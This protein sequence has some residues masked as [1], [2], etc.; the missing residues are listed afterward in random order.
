ML[1]NDIKEI[2]G[3]YSGYQRILIFF[4]SKEFVQSKKKGEGRKYFKKNNPRRKRKYHVPHYRKPSL[5][6][7]HFPRLANAISETERAT[8]QKKSSFFFPPGERKET[9]PSPF[10]SSPS[11]PLLE[12]KKRKEKSDNQLCRYNVITNSIRSNTGKY[13]FSKTCTHL[14]PSL[15]P[16]LQARENSRPPSPFIPFK[17]G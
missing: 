8:V 5:L 17:I 3:K 9:S 13:N 4:F 11:L 2:R 6:H 7:I 12:K 16:S 10:L 15:S 1:M 14:D